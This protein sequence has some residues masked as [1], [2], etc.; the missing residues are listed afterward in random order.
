MAEWDNA[1]LAE[2]LSGYGLDDAAD[3]GFDAKELDKMGGELGAEDD[4]ADIKDSFDVLVTC[5]SEEEQLRVIE[6]A[7]R[8][9][10]ECRALT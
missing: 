1:L 3:A 4:S 8:E 5:S 2:V 6:I 7:Q 9:G 10:L